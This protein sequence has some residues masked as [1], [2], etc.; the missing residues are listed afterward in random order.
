MS[1][2]KI[3]KQNNINAHVKLN[4]LRKYDFTCIYCGATGS[5][6]YPLTADH[7]FPLALGGD[8]QQNNLA[9]SC[10]KCNQKKGKMLLTDFLKKYKIEISWDIAN[11][12]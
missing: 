2:R 5:Q 11:F 8:N 6:K 4:I 9:C 12:L 1:K 7:V 3:S 10:K